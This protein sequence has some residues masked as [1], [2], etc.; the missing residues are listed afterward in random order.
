VAE[1]LP[2]IRVGI[3]VS[4]GIA[5]AG[6]VGDAERYEYTTIGDPVNEAARL[7]ELAK[8]Q[9]SGV[10]TNAGLVDTAALSERK[11]WVELEPVI[12]RGRSTPTRLATLG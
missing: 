8:A 12:V 9:P 6:K 1:E 5:V 4:Q 7:T 10:L 2:G 11:Y 3:G